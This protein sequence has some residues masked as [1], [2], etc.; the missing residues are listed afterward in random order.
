MNAARGARRAVA[1]ARAL[2][3]EKLHAAGWPSARG[4]SPPRF[5]RPAQ[6]EV[7][8]SKLPRPLAEDAARAMIDTVGV[9]AREDWIG[10][11]RRRGRDAALRLRPADLRS[12][13]LT[14]ADMPLPEALRITG[15]GGKERWCR[16]CRS[17]APPS[18]LCRASAPS[19][20]S[21]G[22]PLFRGARGGAAQRRG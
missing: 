14:G 12:A 3:G 20:R 8:A 21:R 1:G 2:G 7:P 16:C 15:K 22:A 9:Q 13:G 17:R 4:S 11:P 10:G 6:P 5:C 19:R 18:R